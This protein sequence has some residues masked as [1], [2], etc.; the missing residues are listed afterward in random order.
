MRQLFCGKEI[1][2]MAKLTYIRLLSSIKVTVFF[3]DLKKFKLSFRRKL[4]NL[5]FVIKLRFNFY[6]ESSFNL[7]RLHS[8]I[9]F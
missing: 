1:V 2:K 6:K 3:P 7:W 9:K 4:T 8:E 5:I